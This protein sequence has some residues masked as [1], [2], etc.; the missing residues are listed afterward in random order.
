[1]LLLQTRGYRKV[2]FDTCVSD[3]TDVWQPVNMSCVNGNTQT[4][5]STST[6]ST[7]TRSTTTKPAT[8]GTVQPTSGTTATSGPSTTQ[9]TEKEGSYTPIVV[10]LVVL[11][12]LGVLVAAFL[13]L[14]RNVRFQT[15]AGGRIP[16][17]PKPDEPYSTLGE[18]EAPSTLDE[19]F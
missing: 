2:P 7:S 13:L 12:L 17:V 8:T 19:D 15:W 10:A 9:P 6:R 16:F 18:L 4:T 1:V 11:V 5:A 14:R 3:E